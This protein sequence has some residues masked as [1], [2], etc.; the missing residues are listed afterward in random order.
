MVVIQFLPNLG[1]L[2][3]MAVIQFMPKIG[4]LVTTWQLNRIVAIYRRYLVMEG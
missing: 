2:V 3:L 4:P 1:T